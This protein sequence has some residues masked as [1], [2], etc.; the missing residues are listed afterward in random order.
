MRR[1]LPDFTKIEEDQYKISQ[2]LT[3]RAKMIRALISE[4]AAREQPQTAYAEQYNS[5]AERYENLQA[6]FDA[7]QHQK[8]QRQLQA[9]AIS[10]CLF[11]L[12]ELDTL[13]L[14]FSEALWNATVERATVCAD[15]QLVFHFKNGGE[16]PV[17]M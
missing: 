6:Q 11:A 13:Q 10:G 16:I 8:E 12:R 1:E 2:E 15:E 9:D 7:L 4:N 17:Q 5:L 14:Q 3:V